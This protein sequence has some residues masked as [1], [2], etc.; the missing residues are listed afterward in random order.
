MKN[1]YFATI[2]IYTSLALSLAASTVPELD[3]Y[4]SI[5]LKELGRLKVTSQT[6]RLHLPQN[7]IKAMRALELEYQQLGDLKNLLTVRRER[8]RFIRNPGASAINPVT[9]PSKLSS[10]QKSYIS[11]YNSITENNTKQI[12]DL[13]GKYAV[14]L[15]NLQTT[16]TKQGKIDEALV[17]MS[18]IESSDSIDTPNSSTFTP[19]AGSLDNKKSHRTLNSDTLETLIHGKVTRWSSYNNQITI[20]YDF[21]DSDQMLDWKGGEIDT[22]NNML[23]CGDTVAWFKLQM[24]EVNRIECDIS[25]PHSNSK[26]SLVIG[27]S[28]TALIEGG[29]QTKAKI[30]Q[31]SPQNPVLKVRGINNI[32]GNKYHSL[33]TLNS[34]QVKWAINEGLTRSGIAN[35][36]ITY[37]SFVGLGHMTSSSSYDNITI[38]GILS[39]KQ[40]EHLKQKL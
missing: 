26:A 18:E 27:N 39:D 1:K 37:P 19:Y 20:S 22:I 23:V 35:A 13:K 21:S 24:K 11:N 36:P 17:V 3:R 12:E 4:K 15:K 38:T 2:I 28:L 5:Y 32:S 34:K 6:Q 30:Y 14:M 25:L 8:E 40:V 16:L 29:K 7:H 33:L 9:T 10:L 31:S